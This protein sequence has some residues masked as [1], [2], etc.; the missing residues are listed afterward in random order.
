[1]ESFAI[2][3]PGDPSRD[4]QSGVANPET[5]MLAI[6]PWVGDAGALLHILISKWMNSRMNEEEEVNTWRKA[7]GNKE[8]LAAFDAGRP[9]PPISIR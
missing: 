5:D 9:V 8:L 2:L 7:F 3:G 4:K 1:M 6:P